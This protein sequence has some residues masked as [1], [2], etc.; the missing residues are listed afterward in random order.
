MA[1][2]ACAANGVVSGDV[3]MSSLRIVA[4]VAPAF[5]F[6]LTGTDLFARVSTGAGRAESPLKIAE[7]PMLCHITSPAADADVQFERRRIENPAC[8]L[9]DEFAWSDSPTLSS[10]LLERVNADELWPAMGGRERI[11]IEPQG[12]AR[13]PE[14]AA[15]SNP[16]NS[17]GATRGR[18]WVASMSMLGSLTLLSL[19]GRAYLQ[20]RG[21]GKR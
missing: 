14:K 19:G 4:I 3:V 12:K 2:R 10:N 5:V 15:A 21:N 6:G 17:D 9:L 1:L 20:S 11:V 8:E 18:I 7:L 16:N 13:L